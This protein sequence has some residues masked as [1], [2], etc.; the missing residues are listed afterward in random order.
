MT[1]PTN[2]TKLY[3]L[4]MTQGGAILLGSMLR[5][6][7]W[8]KKLK[9]T[10]RASKLAKKFPQPPKSEPAED[11]LAIPFKLEVDEYDRDLCKEAVRHFSGE[12]QLQ[13]TEHVAAM[14]ETLGLTED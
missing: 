5:A 4:E 14:L 11:T 10:H 9:K 12:G 6:P 7:G 8:S 1:D 13:A 3:T 2:P